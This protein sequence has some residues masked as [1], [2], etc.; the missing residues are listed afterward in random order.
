[1]G[2]QSLWRMVLPGLR[3]A[4]NPGADED[5]CWLRRCFYFP[6]ENGGAARVDYMLFGGESGCQAR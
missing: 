4:E 5:E 6:E 3:C 2:M 1:M